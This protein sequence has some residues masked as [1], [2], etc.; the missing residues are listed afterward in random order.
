MDIYKSLN[1]MSVKQH[2]LYLLIS[3]LNSLSSTILPWGYSL[4]VVLS[5]VNCH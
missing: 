3:A 4:K 1:E 5:S 2:W